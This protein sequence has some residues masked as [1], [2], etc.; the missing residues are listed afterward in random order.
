MTKHRDVLR[1]HAEEL[2][3][4]PDVYAV[5]VGEKISKGKRTGKKALVCSI[6]QKKPL[7]QLAA[8]EM[9]PQDIEGIPTDIVEIGDRPRAFQA[10]NDQR[11][12]LRP[13]MPGTSTGH[14]EITAGTIGAI[15]EV[16]GDVMLLSNN[17]VFANENLA[18]LGDAILQPGDYDGG[19]LGRGD[20]VGELRDYVPIHFTHQTEPT[21]DPDP[22]PD[23]EPPVPDPGPEPEPE[24]EPPQPPVEDDSDCFVANIFAKVLNK[25]AELLGRETRLK[26]VRPSKQTVAATQ[27]E[28]VAPQLILNQVDAA[29][30]TIDTDVD[31]AVMYLSY[32]DGVKGVNELAGVGTNVHK[33]GRTTGYT[34]GKIMQTDVIVDVQYDGGIARFEDQLWIEHNELGKSFSAGGDSG[35]LIMDMDD[36]AVGLLFA[37]NDVVTFANPIDAVMQKMNITRFIG[38]K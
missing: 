29:L 25:G 33:L 36:N 14:Y 27:Q 16:D 12:R 21:P 37:G 7:A 31:Y 9:I 6:K 11:L 20:K 18:S 32:L 19:S 3:N 28:V 1:K 22:L 15:V 30:A 38:P 17:H 8:D 13:V 34:Q 23:P 5:G 26:A 10:D 4:K 24:P 2:L 35:S